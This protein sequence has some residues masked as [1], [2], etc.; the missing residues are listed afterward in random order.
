[1]SD[2]QRH[3]ALLTEYDGSDFCGWQTQIN[4]RTVQQTILQALQKL[5]GDNELRLTGCS[6]TDAGV[7]ATGH[8]SHFATRCRI[9]A[10]RL[11]LALNSHLPADVAVRDARD[12]DAGFHARYQALG[13][14][15]SYRIWHDP[16]RPAYGRRQVCHVPGPLDLD[17]MCRAMPCLLGRHDFR[18]FMD[19]G[20]CERNPVRT[21]SRISLNC[22]G[23]L[24]IIRVQGD[25][26]LYHMVRILTGTL[27]LVAQ[28]KMPPETMPDVLA[29]GSRK[30][31]GK[32]MPPQGLCLEKVIY[33][34]PLFAEND[35]PTAGE[36]DEYASFTLE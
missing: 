28:G 13:K 25:G 12:V 22:R 34:P 5:T 24:I 30:L 11:P 20:S 15:Y 27:L 36:G 29:G 32:T 21:L 7:H 6:R 31:A 1:M 23:P 2:L 18:A 10:D 35:R 19:A 3:I 8:V 16:C 14:I 9:P 33:D 17:L 26:F 4:G